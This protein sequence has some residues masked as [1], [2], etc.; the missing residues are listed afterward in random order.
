M[1][2]EASYSSALFVSGIILA[3]SWQN[4]WPTIAKH[5]WPGEDENGV[6]ILSGAISPILYVRFVIRCLRVSLIAVIVALKHSE[7]SP[8][9]R[10]TIVNFIIL[11]E[12]ILE[13]RR[14]R[15]SRHSH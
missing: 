1:A 14:S 6:P 2:E 8:K 7:S 11:Q 4:V 15:S 12:G 3:S 10:I 9:A 5:F 13:V